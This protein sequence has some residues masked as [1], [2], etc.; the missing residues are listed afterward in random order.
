M[1]RLEVC[2]ILDP[3]RDVSHTVG[4]SVLRHYLSSFQEQP[5]QPL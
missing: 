1:G 2:D 3:I 5:L 4:G